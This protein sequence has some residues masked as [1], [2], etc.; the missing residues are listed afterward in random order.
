MVSKIGNGSA[1]QRMAGEERAG[2][3]NLGR[4]RE[5]EQARETTEVKATTETG[6]K[7]TK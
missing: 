5:S 2:E 7:T 4:D 3:G 1:A 6:S